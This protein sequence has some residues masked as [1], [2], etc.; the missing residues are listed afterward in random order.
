VGAT[1]ILAV[2]DDEHIR[3]LLGDALSRRGYEVELAPDGVEAARALRDSEFDIVITDIQMPR[4]TGHRLA[5]LAGEIRPGIGLIIMTAHPSEASILETFS[6]GAA[7]YLVKPVDLRD[8]FRAVRKVEQER[9]ELADAARPAR[10]RG[11][12]PVKVASPRPGWIEFEAPSHGIY[13]E[14]FANLFEVL[15]RRGLSEELLQDVRIAVNELGANAVEWGNEGD[16]RRPI[17]ISAIIEP[18]ELVLVIEDQGRGFRPETVPDP[19]ADPEG[20]ARSRREG[21]KR[22]GG[23]GIAM[24]R[25]AMDEIYY[26]REG[27]TVVMTKRF[28]RRPS[29]GA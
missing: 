1:R 11:G 21:G 5:E 18:D 26:N 6:H 9:R 7:A 14:R 17:R 29:P 8:L 22:A 20:V 13:V 10:P 23:Y 25:A 28:L 3:M 24:A 4:M 27:S 2:D 12:G 19:V 16:L 15:L